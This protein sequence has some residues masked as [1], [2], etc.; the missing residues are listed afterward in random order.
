MFQKWYITGTFII[1]PKIIQFRPSLYVIFNPL[2]EQICTTNGHIL[3]WF[4]FCSIYCP[5]IDHLCFSYGTQFSG[6]NLEQI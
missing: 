3:S 1:V 6:S 2:L 5:N 4:I